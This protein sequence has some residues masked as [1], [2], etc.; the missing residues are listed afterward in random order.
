MRLHVYFK[1]DMQS[2]LAG[3]AERLGK[4]IMEANEQRS[5]NSQVTQDMASLRSEN[6]QLRS[7]LGYLLLQFY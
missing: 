3:Y 6:V 1:S 7:K 2:K 4:E 5:I